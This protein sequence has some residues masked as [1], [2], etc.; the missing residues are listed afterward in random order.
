LLVAFGALALIAGFLLF[1][2][3]EETEEW[4]SWT[5]QPPLTAAFLGAGF[6]AAAVLFLWTVRRGDWSRARVALVPVSLIALLLL[7]ATIVH[8]ERFHD[9]LFGWFW[10]AVYLLAPLTLAATA[11]RAVVVHQRRTRTEAPSTGAPL[12]ATLR[13]LLA[14]QGTAMLGIGAYLFVAPGS[15]DA[16]WPWD[17]TP[18][19]ARAVGAFLAGFGVS[20]LHAALVN[21]LVRFDGAALSY[22]TLGGLELIALARYT[23]DLTGA[24]LDSW[25]YA[26]FLASILLCG[27]Y[28]AWRALAARQ[29]A[30]P[31]A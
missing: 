1:V 10:K 7:V 18:L 4:F 31:A 20:A 30:A 22:A 13:G 14:V 11:A 19:T 3:S 9:D 26:A 23:G 2:L 16:L 6:W 27:A 17:L 29:L 25:L 24:D 8:E 5:I 15:A 21:D 28:G 12:P